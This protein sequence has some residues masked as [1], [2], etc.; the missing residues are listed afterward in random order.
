MMN[1]R[2]EIISQIDYLNKELE[3]CE[4]YDPNCRIHPVCTIKWKDFVLRSLKVQEQK[5]YN[6]NIQEKQLREQ[7]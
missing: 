1:R 6:L 2:D 3:D 5:L 4:K 7:E